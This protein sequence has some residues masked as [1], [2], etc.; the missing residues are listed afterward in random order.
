MSELTAKQALF[1]SEYLKDGN[2]AGAA[3]RAGFSARTASRLLAMQPIKDAIERGRT[4]VVDD[5]GAT[6]KS[7]IEEA[8]R[9]REVAE[10]SGNA[11]AMVSAVQLKARL[12]G[13]LDAE[14]PPPPAPINVDPHTVARAV[15]DF[16]REASQA[17]GH[18]LTITGPG[19][20][21]VRVADAAMA[22]VLGGTVVTGTGTIEAPDTP[23][24]SA[25]SNHLG[26]ET[27]DN[28]GARICLV[29]LVGGDRKWAAYDSAGQ[30][31]GF[32][33][34]REAAADLA[35]SL[36]SQPAPIGADHE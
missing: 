6:V 12:T 8:E 23:Q 28:N 25:P 33:R 24:P 31:H 26:D 17:T 14:P 30:L 3:Q 2:G 35:K 9:A 4:A 13:Q 11:S 29:E 16:L 1:V 20:T 18:N 5:A 7:L 22:E 10:Q 34:V 21:I 15:V 19:E 36:P 32:R 27:F